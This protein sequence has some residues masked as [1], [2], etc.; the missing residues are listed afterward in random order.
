L[1]G[2]KL[3]VSVEQKLQDC[4]VCHHTAHSRTCWP[5]PILALQN[6]LAYVTR[7][8]WPLIYGLSD[9]LYNLSLDALYKNTNERLKH[10]EE[11]LRVWHHEL[12]YKLTVVKLTRVTA[13]IGS[14]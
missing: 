8:L 5:L 14:L 10:Y 7:G 11:Y 12:Y 1:F 6:Y 9:I 3:F 2:F 4:V 13:K